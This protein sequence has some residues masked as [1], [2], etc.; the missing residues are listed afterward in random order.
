MRTYSY[1]EPDENGEPI[2]YFYTEDEIIWEYWTYW[3]DQ[4]NSVGKSSQI[5]IQNCIDDWVVL[6]WAK[7]L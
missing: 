7:K 4:M 5:N 2:E 1:I 3:V 6:H